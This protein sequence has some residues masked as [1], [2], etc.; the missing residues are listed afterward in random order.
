MELRLQQDLKLVKNIV[1]LVL[2]D[3][4][5]DGLIMDLP[6]FYLNTGYQPGRTPIMERKIIEI[7]SLGHSYKKPIIPIIQRTNS[8]EHRGR[9]IEILNEKKI[10][11][12]NQP[13]EFLSLL[14]K[15]SKCAKN[16]MEKWKSEYV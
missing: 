14:P 13:L 5:I 15:I 8:P 12:F 4:N 9:V 16:K 11:V 1:E 2:S 7:M 3:K 10:P 6:S